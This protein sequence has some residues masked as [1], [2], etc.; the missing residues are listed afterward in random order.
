MPRKVT[1][2]LADRL[3]FLKFGSRLDKIN[4]LKIAKQRMRD[5]DKKT[6]TEKGLIKLKNDVDSLR[7]QFDRE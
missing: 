7:N 3:S 6:T 5:K 2:K 1:E 4:K